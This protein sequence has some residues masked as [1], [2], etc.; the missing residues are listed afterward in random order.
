MAS[1]GHRAQGPLVDAAEPADRIVEGPRGSGP[2]VRLRMRVG[3]AVVLVLLG[4]GVAVLVSALGSSG[5]VTAIGASA[6]PDDPGTV[7]VDAPTATIYVHLLG[8]VKRPGLYQ[9]REGARAVDAVAAAGGFTEEADRAQLNLAR[10]VSDGEQIHVPQLGE[11]PAAAPGAQPGVGGDGRVNLNTAD[12]AALET[13]PRVGPAM[14]A[15]IIDWRETNGRF[16]TVED[17]QAV[18][19]VG[20]K[21]FAALKDLVTV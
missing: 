2:G 11:V 8:A 12:A 14:A 6:A 7:G 19:G 9:L 10:F 20:E 15:R 21:T 1:H 13:L 16:A 18:S 5:S 17:L 4:L 3:A